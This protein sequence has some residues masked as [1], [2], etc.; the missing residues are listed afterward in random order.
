MNLGKVSVVTFTQFPQGFHSRMIFYRDRDSS[1][2]VNS[3]RARCLQDTSAVDGPSRGIAAQLAESPR[4]STSVSSPD[5]RAR[6]ASLCRHRGTDDP[7][8]SNVPRILGRHDLTAASEPDAPTGERAHP[9]LAGSRRRFGIQKFCD[10]HTYGVGVTL[11]LNPRPSDVSHVFFRRS[12][13]VR[14]DSFGVLSP[15]EALLRVR[16]RT[17]SCAGP[18]RSRRRGNRWC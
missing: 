9:S 6:R 17:T 12:S 1:V 10:V 3:L 15:V 7:V 8:H 2:T 13:V 18:S 5:D 14:I 11:S 4:L 16:R